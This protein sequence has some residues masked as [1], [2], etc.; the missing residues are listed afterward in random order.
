MPA[1]L[2]V[3]KLEPLLAEIYDRLRS[4]VIERLPYVYFIIYS[5]SREGAPFRFD[6]RSGFAKPTTDLKCSAATTSPNCN[7]P[8][9]RQGQVPDIAERQQRGTRMLRP[10]RQR[11]DHL[12]VHHRR[13]DANRRQIAD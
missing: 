13:E 11:A 9:R 7:A 10:L 4:V 2:D 12:D 1:R 3:S 6:T 5:Y 8:H